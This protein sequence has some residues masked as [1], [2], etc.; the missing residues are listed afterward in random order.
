M[1]YTPSHGQKRTRR[2]AILRCREAV[3]G[4]LTTMAD[5]APTCG[6]EK[7]GVKCSMCPAT[8]VVKVIRRFYIIGSDAVSVTLRDYSLEA[9][10]VW[11]G[12]V[13]FIA[14]T[15]A[16]VETRVAG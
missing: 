10:E 5:S 7:P 14:L 16:V 11:R 13:S 2:C 12:C 1:R 4:V 9:M 6:P 3:R 15:R 8:V